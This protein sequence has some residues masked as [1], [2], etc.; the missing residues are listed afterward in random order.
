MKNRRNLTTIFVLGALV[1]MASVVMTFFAGR[2]VIRSRERI[3]TRISAVKR[4]DDYL[5][6][7]TTA[8]TGQR[9]YLLTGD[10]AYLKPYLAAAPQV[11]GEIGDLQQSA[12]FPPETVDALAQ[13]SREKLNELADSIQ[14]RKAQGLP[15]ALKLVQTDEGRD[16][17]DRIRR[18]IGRARNQEQDEIQKAGDE[19]IRLNTLRTSAFALAGVI[20]LLF[21]IWA[22]NR[23]A[24]DQERREQAYAE[25]AHEREEAQRQREF[26]NV[27]LG[28]I[29]DCVI[30]ADME[31][32]ITF[33]NEVAAHLTGWTREEAI[34][35]PVSDIF[36]IINE[37]TR[38]PVESPVSK[39][40][41]SGKIV[42]LANHTL[43][44]CKDGTEVPID[45]SGAPIR[46]AA[47]VLR[48][49]VLVFRDFSDYKSAEKSLIEAKSMAEAASKA[50]DR[51]LAM[52]SHELR[53]PL[54]PVLATL[55]RWE[56]TGELSPA[57]HA[58]VEMMRRSIELEARII[59][60]LLDLTRIAKGMLSLTAEPVNLHSLIEPL[61][62]MY[63]SEVHAKGLRLE[64]RLAAERPYAYLDGSRFQQIMWNLLRNA[65]K[66]TERGGQVVVETF[67]DTANNDVVVR[68]TDTGVGMDETTLSRLFIPFEQGEK[69][70]SRRQGGLGL[71]LAISRALVDLSGGTIKAT[72]PGLG[73]GS[74]F[75]VAFPAIEFTPAMVAGVTDG[76]DAGSA[77]QRRTILLVEDHPDTAIAMAR[78]LEA[79]GHHLK[80]AD[81]A[82]RAREII[83]QGGFDI[84]LCDL[85]LPDGSGI[86]VVS[87]LRKS[88]GT[89]AI[90]ISGF[91]MEED[92]ARCMQ[93]GFD[94]HLTKPVNLRQLEASM[95]RLLPADSR[96]GILL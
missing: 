82:A 10:E 59:D 80:L 51:F 42:G 54:A 67:N 68:V 38:A 37:E 63:H 91:G 4:L 73:K 70:I 1:T 8:E 79:R 41:A 17:M 21:L 24:R 18:L 58:D 2:E 90:A 96:Q 30:V 62:S 43:L 84:M 13:I 3:Q 72:S 65:A 57:V 23:I 85:G 25:L 55:N 29:G 56:M 5:L 94:M 15:A 28:S 87:H 95:E 75:E 92:L 77:V 32:K 14:L 74:V 50:K 83:D 48:G 76:A 81:S 64:M 22:F 11:A 19:D 33:I 35:M 20:N 86:D 89:P 49:V 53:T 46:D 16:L 61:S 34:S 71:G 39:V 44:I 9:G 78:L 12:L 31:G 47:G 60:D 27:T 6:T 93:A 66:F 7:I 69:S 52:L 40:I 45:D 88:R 26:L 36:K